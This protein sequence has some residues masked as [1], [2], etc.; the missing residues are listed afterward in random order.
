MTEVSELKNNGHEV[1]ARERASGLTLHAAY[2]EAYDCNDEQA[3][4]KGWRLAQR[5]EI[6]DRIQW[7]IR[8]GKESAI[9]R[10]A[11]DRAWV[12]DKNR[13]IIE[14]G[15]KEIPVESRSGK[16]LGYK[17]ADGS[18]AVRA[19]E[20]MG[21][22]FGMYEAKA[23]FKHQKADPLEGL[24]DDQVIDLI[25]ETVATIPGVELMDE[26]KLI[27]VG[28]VREVGEATPEGEAGLGPPIPEADDVST[29]Q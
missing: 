26:S 20:L 13:K 15:L 6:K 4:R 28:T 17:M 16:I 10:I 2:H 5:P 27:D 9:E 21:R 29:I 19:V 14:R 23:T 25:R 8:Q 24:T 12:L 3:K 11:V 1:F 18:A 7:L 22:E